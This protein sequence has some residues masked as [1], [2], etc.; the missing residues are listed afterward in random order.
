[1][2]V[3]QSDDWGRVGIRD[4]EGYEFLQSKGLKL[5]EHPYDFYSLETADDVSALGALLSRHRD[6]SSRPACMV[7]NIC[8]ANLDF[9]A[10][11]ASG[12]S[13]IDLLPLARG[14]P[15]S[16]SRPGLLEAYRAGIRDGLFYPGV[17]GLTHF[18]PI[19]VESALRK[20][21]EH[22]QLLQLLWEAETPYIY[23][24]M[25]WI[26]YEHWNPEGPRAG[27]LRPELQELQVRKARECFLALFGAEPVSACAPGY[28]A[29]HDTRSAWSESG[30]QIAQNGSA[31]GWNA[32]WIDE[33]GLLQL[34]RAMDFEP[35][36]RELEIDKYIQVADSYVA[37]GLP[38]IISMHSINFHSTLKDFRTRSL[39]ALDSLLQALEAKYPDLLYVHDQDLYAIV[40]EGAF[41][42]RED[43]I[44]VNAQ[45]ESAV[46]V[47][48]QGAL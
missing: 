14:L 43:R 8:M 45:R 27:Y 6:S 16:W 48:H 32:P 30:I 9:T 25:P 4:R 34:Y 21:G 38:V 11:K 13:G 17:H 29:N 10:M 31:N 26:G 42:S 7:M 33:I 35:G 2:V 20:D 44:T 46:R 41:R 28:Y 47:A 19:A 18:C 39:E 22:A 15:G 40:T 12:F 5:G 24:R 23:W 1:L 36:Q 3:L 37:R